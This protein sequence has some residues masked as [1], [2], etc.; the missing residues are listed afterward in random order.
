MIV[1]DVV[2]TGSWAGLRQQ[3]RCPPWVPQQTSHG[4]L[5]GNSFS[6]PVSLGRYRGG[7][8]QYC[9]ASSLSISEK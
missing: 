8:P 4:E 5:A 3:T 2:K 1:Q 6:Q 7:F 9:P